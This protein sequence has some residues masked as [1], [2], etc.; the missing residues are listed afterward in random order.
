MKGNIESQVKDKPRRGSAETQG[1][2]S[3][4]PGRIA[5][6]KEL[7]CGKNDVNLLLHGLYGYAD[8]N[9]SKN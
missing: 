2:G 7:V 9:N 4:A 5:C 1:L 3:E 8:E 6:G